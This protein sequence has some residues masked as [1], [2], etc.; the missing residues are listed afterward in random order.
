M[1]L[2]LH[3]GHKTKQFYL[4]QGITHPAHYI[5]KSDSYNSKVYVFWSNLLN[6]KMRKALEG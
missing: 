3:S 6:V 5:R 4:N 2:K 1:L